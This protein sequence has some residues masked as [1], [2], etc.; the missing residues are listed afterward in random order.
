MF[1]RSKVNLLYR[2]L[3]LL[4][5]L[6]VI[7]FINDYITLLILTIAFY[8]LTFLERDIRIIFLQ[9]ITIILFIF[10][11]SMNSYLLLQIILIINYIYYFLGVNYGCI[12]DE[13]I[14]R[15]LRYIRFENNN[16]RKEDNNMLCTIF[17]TVHIMILLLSI[18]VG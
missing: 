1:P 18:M 15:N 16:K 12:S 17:V 2:L 8:V 4:A 6:I 13:I 11:L 5:F 14:E 7:I 10:C 3:C 9:I